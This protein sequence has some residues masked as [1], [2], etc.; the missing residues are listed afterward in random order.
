[1]GHEPLNEWTGE[2]YPF[3]VGKSSDR[4]TISRLETSE[5]GLGEV[6]AVGL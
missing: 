4:K 3:I 2:I 6:Q 1:V 5:A